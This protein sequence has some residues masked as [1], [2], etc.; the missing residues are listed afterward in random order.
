MRT[1]HK[2]NKQST[3]EQQ[4]GLSGTISREQL[5][6]TAHVHDKRYQD[7]VEEI[8]T[9]RIIGYKLFKN[10]DGPNKQQLLYKQ[11]AH[12]LEEKLSEQMH[13]RNNS[14]PTQEILLKNIYVK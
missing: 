14:S 3:S 7:L 4:P 5:Q 6:L 13:Y 10:S 9:K 12:I 1:L 2:K 11:S 8:N